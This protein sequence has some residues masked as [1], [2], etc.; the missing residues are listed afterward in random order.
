[1]KLYLIDVR[2]AGTVYVRADS[3]EEATQ[4]AERF[5]KDEPFEFE[6]L[7]ISGRRFDDPLLPDISLSPAFTGH[8][9]WPDAEAE[10]AE[11]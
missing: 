3:P 1:M 11:R 8:G 6:G 9:V 10:L 2:L 7:G 5:M 4:K